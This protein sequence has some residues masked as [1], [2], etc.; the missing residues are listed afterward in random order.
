MPAHAS[1]TSAAWWHDAVAY[2]G[3]DVFG[4]TADYVAAFEAKYN[5]TPDY[6]EASASAAGAILQLAI[7]QAGSID[8]KAVRDALA[9][10]DTTTFYGQ[11]RFGETGQIESLEPPVFQIQDGKTVTVFPDAIKQGD[12]RYGDIQ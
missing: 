5:S 2:E 10:M 6:A 12:L 1:A 11:V 3:E 9:S 7:E 8:H 4:S